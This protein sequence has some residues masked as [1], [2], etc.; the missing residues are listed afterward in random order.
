[1]YS[2]NAMILN[3]LRIEIAVLQEDVEA[4]KGRLA[5][6]KIPV[7][8]TNDISANI[9][10]SN[11]NI[12]NRRNGNLSASQLNINNTI[13]LYLPYEHIFTYGEKIVPIG[14]R[15][16]IAFVGAN[17]ND[18]KIIGRYDQS[19][20]DLAAALSDYIIEIIK[21][22]EREKTIKDKINIDIQTLTSNMNLQFDDMRNAMA[23]S[24]Q[25]LSAQIDNLRLDDESARNQLKESELKPN[26]KG[27]NTTKENFE[28]QLNQAV[29]QINQTIL[30]TD[31]RLTNGIEAAKAEFNSNIETAKEECNTKINNTSEELSESI[32]N[33]KTYLLG[34]INQLQEL[35]NSIHYDNQE[36]INEINRK[37]NEILYSIE[38]LNFE[39]QS[40]RQLI[41]STKSYLLSEDQNK[42]NEAKQYTDDSIETVNIKIDLANSNLDEFKLTV[43]QI[44]QELVD[45]ISSVSSNVAQDAKTYTDTEIQKVNESITTSYTQADDD[46]RQSITDVNIYLND[47]VTDINNKIDES[48]S[49]I[50]QS[51]ANKDEAVREY[52]DSSSAS[53]LQKI[54]EISDSINGNISDLKTSFSDAISDSNT[55]INSQLS[56]AIDSLTEQI[57]T[58]VL[59]SQNYTDSAIDKLSDTIN[60]D[61]AS[62]QNSIEEV[63]NDLS[64]EVAALHSEIKETVTSSDEIMNLKIDNIESNLNAKIEALSKTVKDNYAEL[65]RD[66]D[67][68]RSEFDTYVEETDDFA[69]NIS[70]DVHDIM[71]RLGMATDDD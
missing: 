12:V 7:I 3:N 28:N 21:L 10:T 65:R 1:M 62:A 47:S 58:G 48:V 32:E 42:F 19:S 37:I 49:T 26:K 51:I 22:D 20:S 61:F 64:N 24:E 16:L 15:F 18:A 9:I 55:A 57:A 27:T 5:K 38:Q 36:E 2:S 63:K 35:I 52:I 17:I 54:N 53:T 14:T 31:A 56:T 69:T 41:E 66:L 40:I 29:V 44:K 60:T 50:N 33:N 71:V 59:E 43:E 11:I 4:F 45:S 70:A 39:D 8:M 23:L 46:I 30:D 13:D 6:F 34:L 68:L 25:S 67:A